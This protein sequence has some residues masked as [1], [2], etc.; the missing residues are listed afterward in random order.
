MFQ[1]LLQT[2]ENIPSSFPLD[3][4]AALPQMF[5]TASLF[6]EG[7]AKQLIYEGVEFCNPT[8]LTLLS[9]KVLCLA[10]LVMNLRNLE[11]LDNGAAKFSLFQYVSM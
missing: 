4:E 1:T 8:R 11:Y 3:V 5:E 10:V 9:S 7:T 6:F 2:T